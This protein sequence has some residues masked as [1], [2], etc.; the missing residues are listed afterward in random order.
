M[1]DIGDEIGPQLRKGHFTAN[2]TEQEPHGKQQC[3]QRRRGESADYN[4]GDHLGFLLLLDEYLG[5]E[6]RGRLVFAEVARLASRQARPS[7]RLVHRAIR[8]SSNLMQRD[9]RTGASQPDGEHN[10]RQTRNAPS[11]R[12]PGG[13]LNPALHGEVLPRSGPRAKSIGVRWGISTRY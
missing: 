4:H 10:E 3:R 9:Q 1:G 7:G 13:A 5:G 11:R 12:E 8:E 2:E 6:K